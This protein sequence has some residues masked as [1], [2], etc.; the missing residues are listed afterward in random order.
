LALKLNMSINLYKV[1]PILHPNLGNLIYKEAGNPLGVGTMTV[2]QI[3]AQ[4][5]TLMTNWEGVPFSTYVMYDTVIAKINAAFSDGTILLPYDTATWRHAGK[6]FI[7]GYRS[8]SAVP[9]LIGNPGAK[10][11][12]QVG[13]LGGSGIPTQFALAQNYPNPFNPTTLVQFDVPGASV[14]TIK[15]Y[16]MLGQEVTTLLNHQSYDGATRDVVTF[17]GS[18]LAS[19]VYFYRMTAQLINDNGQ[20]TGAT[21]T[22][23]K[24]MLMVK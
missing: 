11:I 24:K 17:D 10:P 1:G 23:V 6:W 8:I 14:V 20:M 12:Q 9:F 15:V 22:Q 21:F 13:L 2:A 19:G 3:S 5:D 18:A 7:Y 16:N 4:C